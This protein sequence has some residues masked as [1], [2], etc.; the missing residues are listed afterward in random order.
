MHHRA[1]MRR[2]LLPQ[3]GFRLRQVDQ[4]FQRL[5]GDAVLRVIEVDPGG[6]GGHLLAAPRII[7]EQFSQM[8]IADRS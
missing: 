2:P 5:R 6:V 1:K 7:G 3:P 8:Q 4:K